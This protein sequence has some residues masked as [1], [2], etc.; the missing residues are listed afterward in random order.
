MCNMLSLCLYVCL[1]DPVTVLM[2]KVNAIVES[3]YMSFDQ[4]QLNSVLWSNAR[5]CNETSCNFELGQ[6]FMH[7]VI[8]SNQG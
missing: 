4:Q 2:T 8:H 3:H 1:L 6:R 5:L 7:F